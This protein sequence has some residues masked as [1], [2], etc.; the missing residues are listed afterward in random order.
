MSKNAY[1]KNSLNLSK[2]TKI[3]IKKVC[4]PDIKF[5]ALHRET[6][7]IF[8]ISWLTRFCWSSQPTLYFCRNH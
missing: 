1:Q 4:F 8:W 7:K 6:F 5:E 3:D 2:K